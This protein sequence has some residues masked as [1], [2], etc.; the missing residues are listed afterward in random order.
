MH[1]MRPFATFAAPSPVSPSSRVNELCVAA[2][3]AAALLTT[4]AHAQRHPAPVTAYSAAPSASAPHPSDSQ[5]PFLDLRISPLADMHFLLRALL[6]PDEP[7][8]ALPGLD[9]ALA[10]V[11]DVDRAAVWPL[12]EGLL[13]DCASAAD[14]PAV[15]Q[16]APESLTTR[17]GRTVRLRAHLTCLAD[18]YRQFEPQFMAQLWPTH[19]A[20]IEEAHRRL[21]D[22]LLSRQSACYDFL[23]RLLDLPPPQRPIPVYL[24]AVAPRPGGFTHRLRGAGVSFVSI[25]GNEGPLLRE[26][27]IHESIHALD[28]ASAEHP[29]ALNILRGELQ[30][31]GVARTDPMLRDLPHTLMFFAA[32]ETIR[33]CLDPAHRDYGDVAGYYAKVPAA[34]A[35]IRA[36][37]SDWV[38][39][40]QPRAATVRALADATPRP[41]ASPAEP[42]TAFPSEPRTASP[43]EPRTAFPAEPR[44]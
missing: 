25:R 18:A 39:G 26:T 21:C 30:Q 32:A 22:E 33:R 28:I 10:A 42:R 1:R 34:T 27:V 7:R 43:A 20:T 8:P 37:W 13:S 2:L 31:R 19:R 41:P 38:A 24:V 4:P 35:A 44:P 9:Q 14:L 5:R 6:A 17:D 29:S 36:H 15:A 16:H 23:C 11:A 40:T 12:I 3:L